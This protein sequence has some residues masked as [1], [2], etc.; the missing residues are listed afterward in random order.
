MYIIVYKCVDVKK[1]NPIMTTTIL[2]VMSDFT[3]IRTLISISRCSK[4]ANQSTKQ[5]IDR[6]TRNAQEMRQLVLDIFP[7]IKNLPM[8][9][10]VGSGTFYR[11][12]LQE[13]N[14]GEA[15]PIVVISHSIGKIMNEGID[16][17]EGDEGKID[18]FLGDDMR[19]SKGRKNILTAIQGW[20]QSGWPYNHSR[21]LTIIS[22]VARQDFAVVR[23]RINCS[24]GKK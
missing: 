15:A 23:E 12:L 11:N 3:S 20:R 18:N 10:D 17:F 2:D 1:H 14:E 24:F 21:L 16:G 8:A 19:S 6:M 13:F 5:Q 9:E 7:T 4:L 22:D